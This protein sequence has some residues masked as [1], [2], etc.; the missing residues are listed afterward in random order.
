MWETFFL[1]NH[2]QNYY[3]GLFWKIKIEH[4]KSL[5]C[6]FT[7]CHRTILKRSCRPLTSTL[8]KAFLKKNKKSFG[9]SLRTSRAS[10]P[11]SFHSLHDFWR[12]IFFFLYSIACITWPNFIVWLPLL[13]E[14]LDNMC[15]VFVCYPGCARLWRHKFKN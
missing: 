13:L 2:T 5:I 15:I 10:L 14:I 4:I 9:T 1:K 6:L 12:K 11:T 3:Q 7:V 8:Y